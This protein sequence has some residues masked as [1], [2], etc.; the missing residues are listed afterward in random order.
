MR[1]GSESSPALRGHVNPSPGGGERHPP[2]FP[3]PEASNTPAHVHTQAWSPPGRKQQPDLLKPLLGGAKPNPAAPAPVPCG[4][5]SPE[6]IPS[7]IGP[8]GLAW[9]WRNE[10]YQETGPHFF[11]FSPSEFQIPSRPGRM[12]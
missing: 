10:L 11:L 2:G 8:A 5:G 6:R 12:Q 9:G 1:L 4:L 3:T 7:G